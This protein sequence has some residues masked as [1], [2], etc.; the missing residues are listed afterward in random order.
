MKNN[1]IS[2]VLNQLQAFHFRC[3]VHTNTAP[4]VITHSCV[5]QKPQSCNDNG[6]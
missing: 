5:I 3:T 1:A 4:T 2:K 6:Y